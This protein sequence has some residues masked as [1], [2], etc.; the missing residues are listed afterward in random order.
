M[1]NPKKGTEMA[2]IDC[3]MIV[4]TTEE[5]SPRTIGITSGTKLGVEAQ[6]E[7]TEAVKLI[8]KGVLKAQK[9]ETQTITGHTLTLT[10]NLTIMELIEVLQGGSVTKDE[11]GKITGYTPPV[12][13]A[14]Y[15]PVRFTLDAY[16][17]QL[18]EGGNV[19]GYEKASYPGCKGQP[20]GL[21]SEDDVFRVNEYT[22]NSAPGK[23]EAPYSITYVEELP[24]LDDAVTPPAG[25]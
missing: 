20:I 12:V 19:L 14:E 3:C 25:A 16:S 13:G 21:N 23:G 6:I 4:V 11:S 8:I 7:T 17:S 2:M 9:P 22:I 10:D 18:D 15:K 24:V 5:T 1:A